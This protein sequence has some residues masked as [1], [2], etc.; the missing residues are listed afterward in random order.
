MYIMNHEKCLLQIIVFQMLGCN[1]NYINM[2][3][4]TLNVVLHKIKYYT[5]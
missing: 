1:M 3:N 4:V 5:N 2:I